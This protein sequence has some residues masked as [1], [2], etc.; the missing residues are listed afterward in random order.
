VAYP[1]A[2]VGRDAVGGAEQ[3]VAAIDRGL[4][5]A[6]HRSIV[7]APR[8]SEVEGTLV[9][10]DIPRGTVDRDVRHRVYDRVRDT[11][12]SV[13]EAGTIDLVHYHGYD[14]CQYLPPE[15]VPALATLHLPI[16]YYHPIVFGLGRSGTFLHCVSPSQRAAC[17]ESDQILPEIPNG[18]PV[19]DLGPAART[20]RPFAISLGRICPEKNFHT[21]LEAG[22]LA[23]VP[24]FLA[25]TVFP[26]ESHRRYFDQEVRPRLDRRRRFLGPLGF[27][28]KR[29]LLSA[30][31][32]LL[33]P[34]LVPETSSLVAME[35]MASGTPVIA[36]RSGALPDLV[37]HG[38]TGFLVED[39]TEMAEAIH[40]SADLNPEDCRRAARERFPLARMLSGYMRTYRELSTPSG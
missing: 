1:F 6:G 39:E 26:Y 25:G 40:A 22:R 8:G 20:R 35:A 3:V 11:I 29:R 5:R 37:E 33:V 31:R 23:D 17:P 32:C 27:R 15:G 2:P 9:S 12:A 38:R 13:V 24:V 36:F 18:V 4:T 19:S 28:A 34:S 10:L 21:A 16:S 7:I 30:A 14:F